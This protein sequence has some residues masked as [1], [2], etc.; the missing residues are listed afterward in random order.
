MEIKRNSQIITH[1]VKEL[2]GLMPDG[3]D[4]HAYELS[5]KNGMTLKVITYGATISE[6]KIPLKNGEI[7]DVVLG[8][9]TLDSYIESFN[10]VSPPYLGT[11]IGRFA[12]RI[13]NSTFSLNN[14]K[15]FLNKNLNNNSLHG[16]IIGFSQKIWTVKKVHIGKKKSSI[17]LTYTSPAGEEN[18]PGELKVELTYTLSKENELI[19]QYSA[20]TTEDTVVNLTH[21][22]Y[23]NLDGHSSDVSEQEL[24][25]NADK[26]LEVSAESI[27]TGRFLYL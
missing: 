11:T 27:P 24:I 3:K 8:F 16:G 15:V 22:S 20:T 17:T 18:Y 19:V 13:Y 2:F 21:H 26:M 23:F 1:S 10:L 25:V 6:L 7:V 9:E 4:I 14:E 12:G 5:N